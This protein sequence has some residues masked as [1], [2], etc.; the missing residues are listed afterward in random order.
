MASPLSG[1]SIPI[2]WY[3]SPIIV[4]LLLS[5]LYRQ[6]QFYFLVLR[7][8]LLVDRSI[9]DRLTW[10]LRKQKALPKLENKNDLPSEVLRPTNLDLETGGQEEP[11]HPA[12]VLTP[13][14]QRRLVHHQNKFARSHTFY[15]P[16]ETDT[17]YA[18]PLN[19]LVAIV[20]LLD[21]HSCLQISLGACTWG[22]DYRTRPAALTATILSCSIT[23][24]ILAGILIML[25]GR[26]TRKKDVLERMFR[27]E[28][29]EEA[30]H[31]MRA[32]SNVEIEKLRKIDEAI[33]EADENKE[34]KEDESGKINLPRPSL[35]AFRGRRSEDHA[36][37]PRGVGRLLSPSKKPADLVGRFDTALGYEGTRSPR[38]PTSL[39]SLTAPATPTEPEHSA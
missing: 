3:L 23:V 30:L 34:D 21:L 10:K 12:S 4:S 9:L 13:K 19:L 31:R 35:D 38:S 24:N 15:K 16:H 5:L 20:L 8:T 6:S 18:F 28:L 1:R 29:T 2:I 22:I 26:R 14:Q 32:Q 37:S 11:G 27:Q 25:G 17:H 33:D 39:R 36:R 7:L